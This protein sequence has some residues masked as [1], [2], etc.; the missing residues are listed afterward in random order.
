MRPLTKLYFLLAYGCS[1][2]G[3]DRRNGTPHTNHARNHP[4]GVRAVDAGTILRRAW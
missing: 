4:R 2:R 1:C 3:T